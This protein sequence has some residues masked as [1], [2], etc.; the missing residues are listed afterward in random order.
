MMRTYKSVILAI[1][2]ICSLAVLACPARAESLGNQ[3]GG[4]VTDAGTNVN[5]TFNIQHWTQSIAADGTIVY[6]WAITNAPVAASLITLDVS[7]DFDPL[8]RLNFAVTA[9]AL[10]T[11]FTINS[12]VVSFPALA[13]VQGAA[14]AATT[15]TT[16]SDGGTLT[17]LYSGGKS[18]QAM[19][20]GGTVF[21]NLDNSINSPNPF[22]SVTSSERS[23]ATGFTP[24]AGSV[25]DIESQF[26]FTLSA[27]DSASGT[28]IFT[29][30]PEPGTI[31]LVFM[32]LGAAALLRKRRA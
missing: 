20:N 1:F 5:F 16:D 3:L 9:G 31:V 8:V 22:D 17:G 18:Y 12:P 4:T 15:L 29:V 13:N 26:Q 2:S 11:T 10:D 32:G 19:Y 23:P 28:S 24:I 30:V 14:S 27:L 6:S 7:A 25:S 21:A